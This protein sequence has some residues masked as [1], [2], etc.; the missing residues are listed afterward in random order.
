MAVTKARR[1]S[2][3]AGAVGAALALAAHYFPRQ[4]EA[5]GR[6][7]ASFRDAAFLLSGQLDKW[8][9]WRDLPHDE[10]QR[11]GAVVALAPQ[12]LASATVFA[13]RARELL[14]FAHG[15]PAALPFRSADPAVG[16]AEAAVPLVGGGLLEYV[17]RIRQR[18]RRDHPRSRPDE[19]AGPGIWLPRTQYAAG[20]GLIQ[21]RTV[22]PVFADGGEEEAAARAELPEV[23][24]VPYQ[25][26]IALP[27]GELLE[28]A[29]LI[30]GRYPAADRYVH[31][32]LENLFA[33]LQTT[34]AVPAQELIRLGAGPMGILNAPTG[35]GKSVLVRVAASWYAVNGLT[36]TLVLPTVEA[37]LSAAWDISQ[38]LEQLGRT[39]TCTPLMS[40]SRLHE[41]AMKAAA[42]IEGSL[43]EQSDKTLWKLD[44]LS[45]GCALSHHTQSS[46]PYP[47]GQE[48]CRG[49]SPLP[50]ATDRA[51]CPWTAT[52]GKY[53]QHRQ[54]CTASVVV[55]NHHNFMT[56]R[57]PLGIRLDGRAVA[58]VSV[59]EFV[60]RRSHTVMIDEVDQ[61]Q[62][63]ALD[64]CS[65]ELV[66]DSRRQPTVPLRELDE[67]KAK[68]PPDA[69]KALCPTI[70]HARYL[71]EFLLASVCEDLLH[72][73]HYEG[74]GPSRERPGVNSTGWH[75]AGSRDRRL[76]TLLFPDEGI[77]SEQEIPDHLFDQLKALRP[78]PPT[79]DDTD[80][81]AGDASL[82]PHLEAVRRLLGDLLAPRGEDLLASVQLE[83]NEVL[84]DVVKDP[85]D[86]GEAVELLIVR[87]WLAELDD[88]LGLLRNKTGQL[89]SLGMRSAR[90]LAQRLETGVAAH[91]LPYGMLGKAI[92]GYRVTGLDNPHKNAE[93]TAQSISGDP[94]TYT[95]QLGSIVSLAL[96]GV[97]RPVLGLSATAYFPQAVREHVHADVKWWMTDAAPDSI[98]AKRRM[99]TDSVTQRAIQ[100]SGIPQQ[101]KREALI[102]L[103]DRLYDT[104]IHDELAR[105]ARTDPD[106]AHAAVVVN[107]YEHCRHLALGIH[108]AGQY[109]GGLCVAVPSRPALAGQAAA[110]ATRHHRADPGRIRGL[111][112]PGEDPC[113]ADGA[114][115]PRPEHRHRHQV[116]HHAGLSVHPAAGPADRS[117]GDVRQCQRRR[118][119]LPAL[120]AHRR[121]GRGSQGGQG[122]CLGPHGHDHAV[123]AR[124]HQHRPRPAGR[125]RR[126]H[127]RRHDPARRARP[128]RRH[129][130]DAPPRRLRLPRGLLA[131]RPRR[132]P[133]P[134]APALAG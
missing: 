50:P 99:I 45:Y 116:G 4:E 78:A 23:R 48:P 83:L 66:L 113:R 13:A 132:H 92:T 65:S 31:A 63:T 91:I 104:V 53:A 81:A 108:S 87:M 35:T 82:P 80:E 44:Q 119:R 1:L 73:R 107:S 90:I 89:R 54:A 96:A 129:R 3:T 12:E 52:C 29:R 46:H 69:V 68:L 112:P 62:S 2:K 33:Q 16:R 117:G 114:D 36:V 18:L 60:L 5:G 56:G 7:I 61:F 126:R 98:R 74:H 134:H 67:D 10:K 72:L 79:S 101:H 43:L 41:R 102:K 109:T 75:L 9:R 21:G 76:I 30:D 11:I 14:D 86:R 51:A 133:A 17:D 128:P 24:T 19:P 84:L 97:E 130:H 105:I 22:I 121:A 110:S 118:D 26:E 37:T 32:V 85:H 25:E 15:E 39:E 120:H 93:L 58:D 94:H 123:R 131:V 6:A 127:G 64:L 88:T 106:R 122:R 34:D 20:S 103:G 55:T 71:S 47:P 100:I 49:L 125:D 28:L 38:D 70:S 27:A 77:T 95:A 115:R 124:V 8:A 59:A 57:F 42:R 111:P 40:P